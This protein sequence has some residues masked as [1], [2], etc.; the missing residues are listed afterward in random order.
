MKLQLRG[1]KEHG[2]RLRKLRG[3]WRKLAERCR[4]A[5]RDASSTPHTAILGTGIVR[6]AS[7][8][9]CVPRPLCRLRMFRRPARLISRKSIVLNLLPYKMLVFCEK[10]RGAKFQNF[11]AMKVRWRIAPC[12]TTTGSE[13][14][15]TGVMTVHWAQ[16]EKHWPDLTGNDVLPTLGDVREQA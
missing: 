4:T 14:L 16:K 12:S 3:A 1:Q 6:S 9:W 11:D 5:H 2:R 10:W 8:L 13:N 15:V 7:P